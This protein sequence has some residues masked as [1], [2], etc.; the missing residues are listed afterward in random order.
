[1]TVGDLKKQLSEC[2]DSKKVYIET[3]DFDIIPLGQLKKDCE[4]D[5]ILERI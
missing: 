5:V 3:D 4:G 1:M 2:D